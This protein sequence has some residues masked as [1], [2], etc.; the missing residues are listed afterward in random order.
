MKK[1]II[2][3]KKLNFI[4]NNLSKIIKINKYNKQH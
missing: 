4:G 3:F 2:L 1:K